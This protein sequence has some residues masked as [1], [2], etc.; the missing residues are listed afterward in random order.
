[1]R[2]TRASCG[3]TGRRCR[4]TCAALELYETILIHVGWQ[5]AK[6]LVEA[7]SC[8]YVGA[9]TETWTKKPIPAGVRERDRGTELWRLERHPW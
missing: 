8:R 3:P 1:M 9:D 2:S 6:V 4:W 5:N 7:A